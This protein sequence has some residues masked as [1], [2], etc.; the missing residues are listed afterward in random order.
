MLLAC[1]KNRL[2]FLQHSYNLQ[3]TAAEFYM[4]LLKQLPSHG[5]G[6]SHPQNVYVLAGDGNQAP[7]YQALNSPQAAVGTGNRLIENQLDQGI[8]IA[9]SF[10]G[11]ETQIRA[12]SN[13]WAALYEETKKLAKESPD[14]KEYSKAMDH[15]SKAQKELEEEDPPDPTRIHRWLETAKYALKALGLT[16][17]VKDA[18]IAA[19]E[20]FRL[21]FPS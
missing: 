1:M 5:F 12:L 19:W 16:K 13:L 11:R 9:N 6:V 8:H 3:K 18:A 4:G 10:N 21:T 20:V 7:T 2:S 14:H 15:V 17:E